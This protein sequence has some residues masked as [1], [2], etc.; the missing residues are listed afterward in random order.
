MKQIRIIFLLIPLLMAC[1]REIEY[2]GEIEDPRLVLQTCYELSEDSTELLCSVTR[3]SFFLS[4]DKKEDL[5][6][7]GAVVHVQVNDNVPVRHYDIINGYLYRVALPEP[8]KAGD[9]VRVSAE[10]SG[11]S[12]VEG[13]DSVPAKPVCH[14][15]SCSMDEKMLNCIVRIQFEDN[16]SGNAFFG[17]RAKYD[18]EV[19]NTKTGQVTLYH[20]NMQ[21]IQTFD[22]IFATL[23]NAYSTDMGYN[24][25]GELFFLPKDA[26]GKE[27]ELI[28]PLNM[29]SSN[30]NLKYIPKRLSIQ[31]IAH[32]TQS[33]RYWRSMYAYMSLNGESDADLGSM[34][35]GMFDS[36]ERVQIYNNVEGGFGIV[37]AASTR[38]MEIEFTPK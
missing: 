25:R 28:F 30:G 6:I 18:H 29:G 8:L 2:N 32:S 1:Q 13:V 15:T 31:C 26:S 34:I 14:I 10:R 21:Q 36:E 27:I 16:S 24:S 22:N 11:Y 3:S 4:N 17:L 38:K 9:Q 23:G 35:G 19:Q 7:A 20:N 33:Y 12:P 5:R 37:S